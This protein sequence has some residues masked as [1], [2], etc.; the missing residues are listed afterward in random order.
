[1]KM[2]PEVIAT[3]NLGCM[4]QIGKGLREARH[5]VPI[6]HSVELLDWAT[7]GPMPPVLVERGFSETPKPSIAAE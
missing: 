7:G 4:T 1:M 2:A 5:T 3:G 6:L